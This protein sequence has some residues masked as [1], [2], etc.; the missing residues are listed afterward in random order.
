[1]TSPCSVQQW[2][3]SILICLCVTSSDSIAP[4][5]RD[6]SPNPSRSHRVLVPRSEIAL[7]HHTPF[8]THDYTCYDMCRDD[9]QDATWCV[10]RSLRKSM[11]RFNFP[12]AYMQIRWVSQPNETNELTQVT[13]WL[14]MQWNKRNSWHDCIFCSTTRQGWKLS[15][16]AR[17]A[18]PLLP[19]LCE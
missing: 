9:L 19:A 7:Q 6:F 11:N 17:R 4:I 14:N 10:W 18:N 13:G 16:D 3:V 12:A 8:Y 1:M 2:S 5:R 15:L